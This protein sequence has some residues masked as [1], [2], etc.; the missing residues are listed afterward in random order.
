[1]YCMH[2]SK[3]VDSNAE[4]C[5]SCGKKPLE[6]NQF[7]Y[8]CGNETK[9]GQEICLNCGSSLINISHSARATNVEKDYHC[10]NCGQNVNSNA[11]ICVS[12]GK[13]PLNGHAHC[14]NC[15]S[16]TNEGQEICTKCGVRLLGSQSSKSVNNS[17][18]NTDNNEYWKE[19][20]QKIRTSNGSYKGKWNWNAFIFGSL[21]AFSK[22]LWQTG[23]ITII[24]SLI[25]SSSIIIPILIWFFYGW[26]GN[27][28]YYRLVE[29]NEQLPNF[30]ELT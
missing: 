12:C 13:R 2:C 15:G 3:E 14:Q 29:Y 23:L 20:L 25:F 21:W 10:R 18:T 6:G 22:G 19:E 1:M 5:M 17:S 4:Y 27:Y 7:C 26:R 30:K 8:S 16:E 9:E 24:L 28:L 11:E